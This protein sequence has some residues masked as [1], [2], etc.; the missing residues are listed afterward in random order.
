LGWKTGQGGKGGWGDKLFS[1]GVAA[2][3][4]LKEKGKP[5]PKGT[6]DAETRLER[7]KVQRLQKRPEESGRK[8]VNILNLEKKKKRGPKFI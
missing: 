3:T 2:V 5:T 1:F 8:V 7:Q 4:T 6:G